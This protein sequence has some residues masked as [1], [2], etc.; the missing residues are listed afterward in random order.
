M[1]SD[2]FLKR[3]GIKAVTTNEESLVVSTG[4]DKEPDIRLSPNSAGLTLGG[5]DGDYSDG[6]IRLMDRPGD[7]ESKPRI[8]LTGGTGKTHRDTR[9]RIDGSDGTAKLGG[10]SA[11]DQDI[12]LRPSDGLL[13]LGG[14]AGP[15]E[16]EY[17]SFGELRLEEGT[18][19]PRV[20]ITADG[21]APSERVHGV[22]STVFVTG[23]VGDREVIPGEEGTSGEIR[24]KRAGEPL[25][26]STIVLNGRTGQLR[27]GNNTSSGSVRMH[28][29]NVP[30][31]PTIRLHAV[32]A[33]A[34]VG[35][36]HEGEEGEAG[37]VELRDSTGVAT[38]ELDAH[39]DLARGGA[40]TA[41]THEGRETV[42][43][44]SN[45]V[46]ANGGAIRIANDEG[47]DRVDLES[48]P[49]DANGGV[50]RLTNESHVETVTLASGPESDEGGTLTLRSDGGG[51]R[52][53]LRGT[54]GT[55]DGGL[56]FLSDATSFP[57]VLVDGGDGR[58][59]L[60]GTEPA[61]ATGAG[62]R[63]TGTLALDDG[64]GMMTDL[65]AE[66]GSVTLAHHDSSKGE[67]GLELRPEDGVFSVFDGNGDTVFEIDTQAKT[68]KK[69]Q[70]YKEGVIG[71][72]P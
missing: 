71:R 55:D 3:D 70:G 36:S 51:P 40:I 69:A 52:I 53:S 49:Q 21:E 28:K 12:E 29:E 6:D 61:D 23:G 33:Q 66:E 37:S 9:V 7:G 68:I 16:E 10:R 2:L 22:Q 58:V 17:R 4:E 67:I 32:D 39:T 1:A 19:D 42:S 15:A 48:N 5:G 26:F 8:H 72:G 20:F 24:L 30:P 43:I 54:A 25:D 38:V 44:L 47:D 57:T 34:I 14:G 31:I 59:R 60:G 11:D 41:S 65:H 63:E 46:T 56:L 27:L 64:A 13:R 18:H 45:H 35:G 50:V 62:S